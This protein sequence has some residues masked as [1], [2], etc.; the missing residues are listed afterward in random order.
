V[1]WNFPKAY[2]TLAY[3]DALYE[4]CGDEIAKRVKWELIDSELIN[5]VERLN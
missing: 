5:E 4:D 3:L 1:K 2:L